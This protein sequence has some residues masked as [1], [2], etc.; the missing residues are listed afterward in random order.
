MKIR[1]GKFCI[2]TGQCAGV[3]LNAIFLPLNTGLMIISRF[4]QSKNSICSFHKSMLWGVLH[5][6]CVIF[7]CVFFFGGGGIIVIKGFVNLDK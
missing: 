5:F 2:S 4:K 1:Q 7:G 6:F 3:S